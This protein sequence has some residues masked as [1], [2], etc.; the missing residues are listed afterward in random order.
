[1][2]FTNKL[3]TL[4]FFALPSMLLATE[5]DETT[6]NKTPVDT[7][8][9]Q[10]Y[11]TDTLYLPATRDTVFID[12]ANGQNTVLDVNSDYFKAKQSIEENKEETEEEFQRRI[13]RDYV[14]FEDIPPTFASWLSS[15][16]VS[17][18]IL[19]ALKALYID[20][21]FEKENWSNGSILVNYGAIML[22]GDAAFMSEK[23]WEGF[24][25]AMSLGIGYRFYLPID[26]KPVDRTK[27]KPRHRY[28]P[29]GNVS[30]FVQGMLS[31]SLSIEKFQRIES[32]AS[33]DNLDFGIAGSLGL[34]I[35]MNFK[36]FLM[37]IGFD[38]GYQHWGDG[39]KNQALFEEGEDGIH[40]S[41]ARGT[42]TKGIFIMPFFMIGF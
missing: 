9:V 30:F 24:K 27:A 15:Y 34:G 13:N 37:S 21:T 41:L 14:N 2:S 10:E 7:V 17:D 33:Y 8:F 42:T 40:L 29:H 36:N 5:A 25:S 4:V 16:M 26:R 39:V 6:T 23:T 32:S 12:T 20:Y 38:F 28:T 22:L 31:P 1:M 35:T 19:I 3:I 11:V 18:I